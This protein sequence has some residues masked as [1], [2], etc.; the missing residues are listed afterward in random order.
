MIDSEAFAFT[1]ITSVNIP[2]TITSIGEGAFM[3]CSNLKLVVWNASYTKN[4]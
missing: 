1:S 2:S 4:P 3:F